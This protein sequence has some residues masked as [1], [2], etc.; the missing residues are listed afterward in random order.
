M[1]FP[2]SMRKS[3][4]RENSLKAYEEAVRYIAG[5]VNSPVRALRSVNESPLFIKKANGTVLTDVDGNRFSDFCLSWGVFI[6][7]HA[8]PQ[9][10]KATR[11]AILNGT[12]YGIPS[13]PETELAKLVNYYVP[14]MEKVRFVNSGTEAVMSAIRLARGFTKRNLI[15]K[16]DGCYHGHADHLLVSAGSGVANLACSSS[17]GVPEGFT[18]YT[19]SLPFN[20]N[21]AVESLF[22]ERG[23]EIAA[24]IVEPVPA[25][26]GV[27]LP[28]ND[29]LL[30]LRK[31]TNQ[32]QS[33]LIFDEVITGFRLLLGG[34]QKKFGII[35]DLTTLGKIIG[36]G[37][38]A[39][40][41]GGRA[42]IMAL[43]APDGPVYQAGTLSGNPVAMSAG[44]ET[45]RILSGEDFYTN[46]EQKAN[47]FF[48]ELSDI[49]AGKGIT[50]NCTGSMF[51]LF[52]TEEVVRSFDDVKK[53]NTDRFSRF[54]KYMLLNN[55]YISPSQF[56]TNFLSAAHT[57]KELI[58]FVKAVKSFSE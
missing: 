26:M 35:P 24:V 48:S 42:D 29:F 32:Y 7:G 13:L 40:A 56:E 34:A 57:E 51:T 39:A 44:A 5:G 14:S 9:V 20:N 23:N 47:L 33:L 37:F 11:K 53:A 6:L 36:G 41:F 30:H 54:F 31:L 12:S 22:R 46:L 4:N 38:P 58:K 17:A 25:N 27:V 2:A 43:L 28:E 50:M 45:I 21:E 19:V 3:M 1:V 8:H 49:I 52:F 18:A 15:V 10:G 16:F 55:I